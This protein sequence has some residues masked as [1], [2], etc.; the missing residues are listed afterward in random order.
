[1]PTAT[2]LSSGSARK[3]SSV[4]RWHPRLCANSSTTRPQ[5]WHKY[6]LSTSP[7]P[8]G[9][10]PA[11]RKAP[12]RESVLV[13]WKSSRRK[14]RHLR[15]RWMRRTGTR[16]ARTSVSGVGWRLSGCGSRCR[17]RRA[18]S[19]RP[20]GSGSRRSWRNSVRARSLSRWQ[21]GCGRRGGRVTAQAAQR[22]SPSTR[23]LARSWGVS[24]T[25]LSSQG[26]SAYPPRVRGR[27]GASS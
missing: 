10:P 20:C 9:R 6:S 27:G 26:S 11:A 17:W 21:L 5:T 12:S 19:G 14:S 8:G 13:R 24:R 4:T 3:I 25:P 22:W 1:M 23:T 15:W 7:W 16:T 2:S 18:R